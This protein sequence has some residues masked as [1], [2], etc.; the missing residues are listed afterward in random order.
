MGPKKNTTCGDS[1]QVLHKVATKPGRGVRLSS[2]TKQVV[3]NVRFFEKEKE[4]RSTINRQAVVK[5]TAE[6]TGISERSVRDIHK[7]DLACDS[8]LLTPVKRYSV[9]RI[10]IN[11]DSFDREVIRWSVHSFY[12]RKEYPII[13][14]VLEKAKAQCGFPGGRY[15]T[16]RVLQ[17]MGFTYRTQDNKKYIYEQ[18]NIIEQRHTYL[19]PI[20]KL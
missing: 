6:A 20:R 3:E 16:W 2:Q 12:S 13:L 11:P 14:G 17:E 15:C 10:R 4:C 7:A 8:H 9:S 18:Q 1:S 5:R 19:Q